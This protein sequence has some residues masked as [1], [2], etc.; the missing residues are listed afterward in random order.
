MQ[1][2]Q[3]G[4]LPPTRIAMLSLERFCAKPSNT[5]RLWPSRLAGLPARW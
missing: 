3:G 1:E 4:P 2:K 5:C